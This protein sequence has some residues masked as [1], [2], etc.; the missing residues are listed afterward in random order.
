MTTEIYSNEAGTSRT[1]TPSA[2]RGSRGTG[3]DAERRAAA[4]R[5]VD[6][7]LPGADKLVWTDADGFLPQDDDRVYEGAAVE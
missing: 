7:S 4:A 2:P 5:H 6:W 3:F 1:A